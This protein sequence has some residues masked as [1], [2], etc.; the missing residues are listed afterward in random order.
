MLNEIHKIATQKLELVENSSDLQKT[1]VELLGKSSLIAQE[2]KKL[3]TKSNEEKREIGAKINIVKKEIEKLLYEKG[4]I[5]EKE[6]LNLQ[7]KSEALDLTMPARK[8]KAGSIHPITQCM[9]ELIQV[10]SKYG[11]DIKE[12]PDIEDDWYNF[13][14]LN[15]DENHPARQM[16]D[17][18]Y[19][20]QEQSINNRKKLLRTHTSPIQIRTMQ[21]EK[22]PYRFIAPGRTYRCDSDLT[23]TPMFHQIEGMVIDKNIHMGHLKHTIIDFIRQFFEQPNIEIQFRPSFFPFTEPSAEVDIRMEDTKKWLEVLGCG[24]VH[25]QILQN[26]GI[27]PS[28]YQGFAFGLGVERFAMLKYGIKDLRHFFEGDLRWLQHYNFKNLDIP[29]LAGG[30]TK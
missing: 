8:H 28:E 17:T 13:T 7:L 24:M 18:F 20:N 19:L 3:A 2:M 21:Q 22:P 27:D 29:T 12:G 1:R 9:D 6:E 30:L 15:I 16:H 10:F 23:H 5:I 25:P 11:F 4:V 14:A 26:V